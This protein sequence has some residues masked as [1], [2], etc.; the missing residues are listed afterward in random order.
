M[1]SPAA[2]SESARSGGARR[3]LALCL[4]IACLAGGAVYFATQRERLAAELAF[5]PLWLVPLALAE[6]A[7]LV[8][9]GALLLRLC[10]ALEVRLS[11]REAIGLQAGSLLANY[12]VPGLGGTSLRAA[13]LKGR[14][15]LP[16]AAFAGLL[17]ATYLLQY[18]VI[19]GL[20]LGVSLLLP[21]LQDA[22]RWIIALALLGVGLL[23]LVTFLQPFG[24][25]ASSGRV[26]RFLSS[27]FTG[28]RAMRRAGLTAPLL[29]AAGQLAATASAFACA[30]AVLG[31]SLR[32][33]Q[34]L[35]VAVL[36]EGSILVNLTPAGLGVVESAAGLAAFLL[37]IPVPLAVAATALRR[38]VNL[39][40]A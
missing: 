1:A 33:L 7:L 20:G 36:A 21:E 26:S 28:W 40:L 8:L 18:L 3:W 4:M 17:A 14:H 13:Y 38:A 25:P 31:R 9:R 10:R 22:V 34:A 35:F 12:L 30:F 2:P 16:L 11:W 39:L 6:A 37:G 23:G 24:A 5:T 29:L 19:C 32:P 15:E 27:A